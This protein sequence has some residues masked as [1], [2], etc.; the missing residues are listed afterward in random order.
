MVHLMTVC[1]A[2]LLW[3]TS[4]LGGGGQNTGYFFVCVVAHLIFLTL[5]HLTE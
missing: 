3:P 5:A 1:V 4:Y 2:H